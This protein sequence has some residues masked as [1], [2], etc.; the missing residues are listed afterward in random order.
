[1]KVIIPLLN[2]CFLAGL[3]YWLWKKPGPLRQFFWPAL[4]F[5]LLC[6]V[7]LGAIYFYHYEVGDTIIYFSDG[8]VLA[9]IA[10]TDPGSYFQI[11]FSSPVELAGWPVLQFQE[12]RAILFV[13][14]T[15]LFC[16]LSHDNYWIAS[17]YF[18]MFAFLG[19]WYLVQCLYRHLPE[20]ASA[21]M[22]AF[23]FFPSSVFWSSGLIKESVAM[24]C[25]FFLSGIFVRIWF[26]ERPG[27]IHW[28]PVLP[29][30]WLLWNLKYYFA[31][32][33]FLVAI[34]NLLFRWL[35]PKFFQVKNIWKA[36][37]GWLILLVVLLLLVS[38]LHPNF[39]PHRFLTVIVDN[40]QDF[41]AISAP[42]DMIHFSDLNASAGSVLMNAPWALISGLFRPF[43]WE[44]SNWLQV[45]V[46]LENLLLLILT[47]AGFYRLRLPGDFAN[48]I[49]VLST[50][51]Y[52][53]S[54][55]IF[56]TLSTPNFGTLSRYRV[57]YIPFFLY[58]LCCHGP[59]LTI[60]QRSV[61]HLVR[62]ER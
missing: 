54:L 60:L 21:A 16:I 1:M 12:P 5:K 58:V 50:L 13:K 46:A 7:S 52:I 11:L 53:G 61:N 6:G 48:K 18:S 47:I 19:S 35:S 43:L 26:S 28:I 23:L 31:A 36:S 37:L 8:V 42:E 40:Y 55:C 15:S 34:S 44:A 39:Y 22:M 49:L 24:G 27:L 29:A 10:R 17:L 4:V 56:I 57:S 41:Y 33:F 3:S 30:A 38:L 45:F 20:K 62:I 2:L 51:V 14:A 32:I 25:L 9:D 59:V